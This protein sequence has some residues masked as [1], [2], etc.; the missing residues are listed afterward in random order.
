MRC[1]AGGGLFPGA[2]DRMPGATGSIVDSPGIRVLL[3]ISQ[4][5]NTTPM[6]PGSRMRRRLM[7]CNDLGRRRFTTGQARFS[8]C[9]SCW[10]STKSPTIPLSD[11]KVAA[12]LRRTGSS[13]SGGRDTAMTKPFC[14]SKAGEPQ[15]TGHPGLSCSIDPGLGRPLATESPGTSAGSPDDPTGESGPD[16]PGP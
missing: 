4:G 13:D 12:I 14:A 7:C 5:G 10:R 16:I 11:R 9:L 1:L 15:L 6:K 2:Q 3:S 8:T